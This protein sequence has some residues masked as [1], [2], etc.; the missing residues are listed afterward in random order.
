[1]HAASKTK[2]GIP[3][4]GSVPDMMK[5]RSRPLLFL[6][7]LA[8]AYASAQVLKGSAQIDAKANI[9]AAGHAK[10][11]DPGGGGAGLLPPVFKFRAGGAKLLTF[12]RLEGKVSCCGAGGPFNGPEG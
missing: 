5:L 1:M 7:L 4:R 6:F 8:S 12:S 2:Q 9:F 10:P 3:C 11:A